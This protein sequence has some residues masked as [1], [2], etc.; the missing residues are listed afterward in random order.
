MSYRD[1]A[2]YGRKEGVWLG[3]K[4]R[5]GLDEQKGL[6]LYATPEWWSRS[7]QVESLEVVWEG[8]ACQR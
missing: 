1:R 8:P 6:V 2:G 5:N 3:L 7:G 4:V